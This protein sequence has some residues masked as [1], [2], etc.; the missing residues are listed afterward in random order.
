MSSEA[1]KKEAVRILAEFRKGGTHVTQVVRFAL[2]DLKKKD[3]ALA[4]ETYTKLLEMG[5]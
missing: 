4:D 5:W 3:K 2:L 1:N